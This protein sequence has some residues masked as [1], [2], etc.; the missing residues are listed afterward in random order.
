[1]IILTPSGHNIFI[2]IIVII[3]NTVI[4]PTTGESGPYYTCT[5]SHSHNRQALYNYKMKKNNTSYK[6]TSWRFHTFSIIIIGFIVNRTLG[7]GPFINPSPFLTLLI[8]RFKYKSH[9]HL[10]RHSSNSYWCNYTNLFHW[11]K[12]SIV[13]IN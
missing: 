7:L 5:R 11:Q 1:M 2:I 12:V 3:Y 9:Y 13:Y 10:K 4:K 8:N 6:Q